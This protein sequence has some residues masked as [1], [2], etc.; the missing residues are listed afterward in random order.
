MS[1]DIMNNILLNYGLSK[2]NL[3]KGG[4]R[5]GFLG[6][7]IRKLVKVGKL[8][9]KGGSEITLKNVIDDYQK[10]ELIDNNNNQLL[11]S[12]NKK[13]K[14]PFYKSIKLENHENNYQ[15]PNDLI[16]SLKRFE[17]GRKIKTPVIIPDTLNL[18]KITYNLTAVI[19]HKGEL[20]SGHYY[21]L[22]KKKD[23]EWIE[24]NDSN[25]PVSVKNN[26]AKKTINTIGYIFLY[27]NK[28]K[29]IINEIETSKRNGIINIGHSCYF[30]SIL[31]FL[32]STDEYLNSN[33]MQK[34][35]PTL[36]N[37]L[38][39]C[40]KV[41]DT[42]KNINDGMYLKT[43]NEKNINSDKISSDNNY[44]FVNKDQN[45]VKNKIINKIG[46]KKYVIITVKDGD[47]KYNKLF[48]N[49]NG[50]LVDNGYA[51]V[52][53]FGNYSN[54]LGLGCQEDATEALTLLLD[55]SEIFPY[56]ENTEIYSVNKNNNPAKK[57]K[58]QNEITS[59]TTIPP[60]YKYLTKNIIE[61]KDKKCKERKTKYDI[62]QLFFPIPS[63]TP[64]PTSPILSPTPSP[65]LPS[66]KKKEKITFNVE[67]ENPLPEA[68][69]TFEKIKENFGTK[70]S[71]ETI[72][73]NN[74]KDM[75]ES[76]KELK[77]IT[78]KLIEYTKQIKEGIS[79]FNSDY[80]KVTKRKIVREIKDKED[81]I[82]KKMKEITDL[83]NKLF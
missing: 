20:N 63:P 65:L 47:K 74:L 28:N 37:F 11:C 79:N 41:T 1:F 19:I 78:E 60:F 27:K 18:Y 32:I 12:N 67:A 75:E 43:F 45:N 34:Y 9:Q 49:I 23:N 73:N 70:I 58:Y 55:S 10:E 16:F 22:V 72:D 51:G 25:S 40:T 33:K 54:R 36:Y 76:K 48:Q 68:I 38:E 24:L 6:K 8:G 81:I 69:K 64:S 77:E 5:G 50:N 59:F 62:Q 7:E 57:I 2:E 71:V 35:R 46:K 82:S 15:S 21:T 52:S 14:F 3:K 26:I 56:K 80:E 17:S 39:N 13:G 83:F 29:N 44:T 31:Q 53:V 4:K 61:I 66:S 30:N 42:T